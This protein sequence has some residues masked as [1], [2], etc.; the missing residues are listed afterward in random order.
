MVYRALRIV[1]RP[2]QSPQTGTDEH[3]SAP[4]GIRAERRTKM[5]RTFAVALA[6]A[7][8]MTSFP[9]AR[10]ASAQYRTWGDPRRPSSGYMNPRLGWQRVSFEANSRS[11]ALYLDVV[12]GRVQVDQAEIVFV[13]GRHMMVDLNDR[14]RRRGRIQIADFN[15]LRN[16]DRVIV[17][18]RPLSY[19]ARI[20]LW[21]DDEGRY[22]WNDRYDNGEW[23]WRR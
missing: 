7:A 14:A 18:A 19:D 1:A 3:S 20:A 6:I 15:Q 11:S 22:G 8:L 23:R 12:R 2:L 16:V 13:D 9:M 21:R 5:K 10:T 4:D 17:T